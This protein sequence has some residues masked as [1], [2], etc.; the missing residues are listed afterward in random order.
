[1]GMWGKELVD[2]DW[3]CFVKEIVYEVYGIMFDDKINIWKYCIRVIDE[4]LWWLKWMVKGGF[5][6]I[7]MF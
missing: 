3:L 4:Y 2:L 7:V 5:N 1:M 6:K